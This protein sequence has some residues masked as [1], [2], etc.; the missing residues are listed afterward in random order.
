VIAAG[1]VSSSLAAVLI[2]KISYR[3]GYR[4]TLMF[5]MGGGCPFYLAPGFREVS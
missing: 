5:C 4:R 3:L 1:A 2:G